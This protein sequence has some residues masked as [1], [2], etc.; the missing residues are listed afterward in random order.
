MAIFSIGFKRDQRGAIPQSKPNNKL[1]DSESIRRNRGASNKRQL[2][3]R[4]KWTEFYNRRT[5]S[6]IPVHSDLHG[7]G[8]NKSNSYTKNNRGYKH[9]RYY[10]YLYPVIGLLIAS[11]VS[12]ADVGGVSATANPIAN[13]QAQ[14]R[15]K[16]FRFYKDHTSLINM[17]G[18]LLV[19]D[20]LLISHH[21]LLMLVMRRIHLRHITWNLSMTTEILKVRLVETQKVVKNWPWESW[22]DDRTYT[23]CRW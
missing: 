22:Y 1:S 18:A 21:L 13:A 17:V 14:L 10:K 7:T 23:N 15:T 9:N 8:C 5:R 20:R 12:A 6:S 19:K 11:P 16:L 4:F 2:W 3:S